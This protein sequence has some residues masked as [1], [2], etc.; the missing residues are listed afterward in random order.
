[1]FFNQDKQHIDALIKHGTRESSITGQY[2][3]GLLIE[4][5]N[6]ELG[7]GN[8]ILTSPYPL[9]HQIVTDSWM[10]HTWQLLHFYNIVVE[11]D[12]PKIQ[13]CCANDC[14]LLQAFLDH[15]FRGK[16]LQIG[17]VWHTYRAKN[18]R[19]SARLTQR[20]FTKLTPKPNEPLAAPT[21][22]AAP[23]IVIHNYLPVDD[24]I[25]NGQHETFVYMT[26]GKTWHRPYG[27]GRLEQSVTGR[28]SMDQVQ[29]DTCYSG[30]LIEVAS[31]D[32]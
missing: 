28:I 18:G 30:H 11:D 14:F 8:S 25:D 27:K 10:K 24:A 32:L 17:N 12:V 23:T 7:T 6:L 2:F 9:V 21:T 19:C 13:L 16:D 31:R 15:G 1:M 4:Q 29:Q 26:M 22:D 20:H 3:R 5:H